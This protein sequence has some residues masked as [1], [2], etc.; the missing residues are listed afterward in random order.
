MFNDIKERPH[1]SKAAAN[2][3]TP[4]QTAE[5]EE[6][7]KP[8]IETIAL[9]DAPKKIKKN[10]R[11]SKKN[12]I[13]GSVALAVII[14][15]IGGWF[16]YKHYHHSVTKPAAAKAIIVKPVPTTVA[17]TLSGLPVAP[18]LNK[19][20]VTGIMIENEIDSR[21]Q[22]GLDQA[23]VVFEALAEGGITRFLALYQDT[24]PSYIGPIRSARPYYVSWCMGFDCD[25]AHVGGSPDALTDISSW[26]VND[27]NQF[28]N[29]SAYERI[30]SREAPHNVYS[31]IASLNTL[32]D[33]KG[34]TTSNFQGFPRKVATPLKV[35]TATTLNLDIGSAEYNV[36]YSYNAADNNYVRSEAGQLMT[37]VDADGTLVQIAPKVVIA[38]VVPF[39]QGALDASDAYYSNYAV[40][41]SGTAYVFQDGGVTVGTWQK[42]SNSAQITFTDSQNQTIKLDPGQTWITALT[43][44]SQLTY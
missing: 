34:Y 16:I 11:L 15:S 43:D 33:S 2:F 17:S 8:A 42:T 28:Y 7:T 26:G 12:I 1:H 35:P 44:S 13:I 18:S 39:S 21:P 14:L 19:L 20:P 31:S 27:L 30:T 23:G 4:E 37:N 5:A 9:E 32:E 22:S 29:G 3:K 24:Q 36:S 40:T 41:G 10:R 38:I 25:Y 6:K